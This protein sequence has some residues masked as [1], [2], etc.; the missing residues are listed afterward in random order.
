[1]KAK[2]ENPAELLAGTDSGPLVEAFFEM[3]H[4]K[5]LYR[6]G[7]LE[8]GIG[9]ERCETVAEHTFGVAVL[10]MV[11]AGRHEDGLDLLKV[12]R[13]ALV[14]DFGEIHAGDLTPRDDVDAKEKERLERESIDRVLSKLPSGGEYKALWEEYVR[15]ESAESRFVR[16]VDKLEMALQAGI[17]E[18]Q[19]L[20]DLSEFFRSAD[21]SVSDRDLR[22]L[23]LKIESL[24]AGF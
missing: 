12:L 7:W 9:R 24:R 3:A 15:G 4:L 23:L 8:R 5:Q 10:S 20:A 13:M 17:Y 1:M 19:Q 16:Q 21:L 18:A 6:Q 14:H 2:A 11:L 22:D